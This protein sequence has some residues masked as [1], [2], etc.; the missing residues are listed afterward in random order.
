MLKL[1][2]KI[3]ASMFAIIILAVP[4]QAENAASQ[5][6]VP[7]S[8]TLGCG[9]SLEMP[10][11]YADNF[12]HAQKVHFT[13]VTEVFSMT[14]D[15]KE[16]PLYRIDF[17]NE[18]IGEWLGVI[19]ME[20]YDVPVTYTLYP[21]S[22]E[23]VAAM[24]A[25]ALDSYYAS[26]ENFNFVVEAIHADPRFVDRDFTAV[27]ENRELELEHWTVMLPDGITCDETHAD[28]VYTATF[29]GRIH[30]DKTALYTVMI[31]GDAA[32]PVGMYNL[33]GE[34]KAVSLEIHQPEMNVFW[35]EAD[36]EAAYQ[37]LETVN[38][39]MDAIMADENFN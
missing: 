23:E 31:G 18:S 38:A 6:P 29:F 28:G 1:T 22:E 3:A 36:Y 7:I 25:E 33:S 17:G 27:G 8:F 24:D 5:E 9:V 15:D 13:P 11:E 26:M 34:E 35:S 32:D 30:G 39:V 16:I 10:V 20:E 4:V 19:R 14:I 21:L 2:K 12:Q 37:M